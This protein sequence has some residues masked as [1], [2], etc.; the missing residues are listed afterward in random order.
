MD[1]VVKCCVMAVGLDAEGKTSGV[2]LDGGKVKLRAGTEGIFL[3][4]TED[5]VGPVEKRMVEFLKMTSS[6]R[7]D[8]VTDQLLCGVPTAYDMIVNCLT[9]ILNGGTH[10]G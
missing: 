10:D 1:R 8:V 2:V 7:A 9:E 5:G 4:I 6:E 3:P